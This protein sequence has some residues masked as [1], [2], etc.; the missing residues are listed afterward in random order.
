M[1]V[2]RLEIQNF[3]GIQQTKIDFVGHTLLVG[4]NNIGKST[5]CQALELSLG[6]DRQGRRSAINEFDFYN[7]RYLDD[8]DCP[9][10]IRI[11]ALLTGV[12][13]TIRRTCWSHLEGWDVSKRRIL[14]R[15]EIDGVDGPGT[16]WCLRLLTVARYNNEEDDF[17]VAT[18]FA[19]AYAHYE[20]DE[21]RVPR[22]VKRSVGFLYL[23][24]L[25]TG[26][27]ALS[28]E[29]GSLLDIILRTKSS[30]AGIWEPLRRRLVALNPLE[31]NGSN[32]LL[33]VLQAIEDRLG[34]YI[35]LSSPSAS[36]KL[37][38]SQLT[39]EHLRGILSFFLAI[40]GDQTPIPFRQVGTGTLNTLVLVL[41]SF[42]AERR[43]ENVIFAMEEPEI[44]LPPHTQR[45]IAR[46]LTENTAQCFVTSHSP[47]VIEGFDPSHIVIL[48]R[49]DTAKVTGTPI[50]LEPSVKAKT[51]RHHIRR[52]FAEAILGRGVVV[53]E[54]V[55]EQMALHAVARKFEEFQPEAYYPLDLSGVTILSS[56]GDGSIAEFGRFFVSLDLPVFAFFDKK[57]RT[58]TER[59]A[60]SN[61]GFTILNGTNYI[62]MELLLAKEVEPDRQWAYLKQ[63]RD[64]AAVPNSKIPNTRP[65]SDEAVR[66]LTFNIL[67]GGKG[68]GRAADLIECCELD[69]LPRSIVC[70]L[71]RIYENFPDPKTTISGPKTRRKQPKD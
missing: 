40:S 71:E 38:V 55:T 18:H 12:T 23:R 63:V 48:N 37:F 1:Q 66:K 19:K 8:D 70:F 14:G 9:V 26:S 33:S 29:R 57:E 2:S 17:E 20:E 28:L 54:G 44:A 22:H 62:G 42:I 59:D 47:Y 56:D 64:S 68:A 16:E 50:K 36:T 69:E 25:R 31:G 65:S 21:S 30:A 46:Y 58:Q 34:K 10:E 52:S 32:D 51:Y 67:R 41:L 6:P 3:R 15:G 61:A 5:I 24:T 13:P 39:R 11:E 53:A 43:E 7:A 35:Q 4:S 45:L 60:L 49:D 27:R